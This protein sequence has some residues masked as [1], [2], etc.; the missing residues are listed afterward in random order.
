MT[1]RATVR[2]KALG[3]FL[4]A[5]FLGAPGLRGQLTQ[6]FTEGG[7]MMSRAD[8]T[9]LL[10]EYELAL[11]SSAYS[12]RMK[13]EIQA[14][15]ARVRDRL[16]HGD[17]QAGD[18]VAIS[19]Q[20]QTTLPDTVP[21]ETGPKITLPVFGEIPLEGVLR[22]EI[23]DYLTK[24]LGKMIKDPV[25]R[26][27]ALMRLSVQGAVGKPGFYVVPSDI[28]VTDALMLAGGPGSNAELKDLRIERG[29]RE[30]Y[31]GQELQSA[32]IAGRTLDQL[33]LQAGDQIVL[34]VKKAGIWGAV[35]RYAIIITSALVLGIRVAG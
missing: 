6:D 30:I 34:P 5:L 14:A 32:L 23:T 10:N 22:S 15:A 29:T 16:T 25:V 26:A 9:K 2:F 8:L 13:G 20:G 19:V 28:L 4:L 33:S 24:A 3:L 11:Q 1:P 12:S 7:S 31:G 21:V 27:Q 18:R 17:F 35:G